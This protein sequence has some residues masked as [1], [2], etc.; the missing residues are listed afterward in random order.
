MGRYRHVGNIYRKE[1]NPWPGVIF[2][3]VLLI[4]IGAAIG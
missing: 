4:I 1:P 3:V 2:F